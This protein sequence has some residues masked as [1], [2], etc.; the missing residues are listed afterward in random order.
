M[1]DVYVVS[2]M[3]TAIG[4]FGGSLKTFL[5]TSWVQP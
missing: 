3:R 4:G 2:A 1:T 5:H